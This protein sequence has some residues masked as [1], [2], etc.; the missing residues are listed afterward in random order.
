MCI[1]DSHSTSSNKAQSSEKTAISIRDVCSV[2]FEQPDPEKTRRPIGACH[3]WPCL[4]IHQTFL[5][6]PAITSL[7]V[8]G[9]FL[10]WCQ[11]LAMSGRIRA[12]LLSVQY[13][14]LEQKGHAPFHFLVRLHTVACQEWPLSHFHQTL[15]CERG[16][17]F[18]GRIC[19]FFSESH[20]L[21][22]SGNLIARF[23]SRV[24]FWPAQ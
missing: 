4:Q 16:E 20:S 14:R 10:V 11:S 22:S 13:F 15:F 3:S 17:Q 1:R 9:A 23:L 21:T 6:P 12:R 18:S 8:S 5:L 2:H 24:G 19:W 7:G